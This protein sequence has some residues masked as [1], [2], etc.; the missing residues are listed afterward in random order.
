MKWV[1]GAGRAEEEQLAADYEK[2]TV[3]GKFHLG[4]T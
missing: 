1:P 3:Q 2:S 4:E